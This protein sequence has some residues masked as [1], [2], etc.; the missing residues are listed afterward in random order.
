MKLFPRLALVVILFSAAS[1]LADAAD[2]PDLILD[3]DGRYLW[4]AADQALDEKGFLSEQYLGRY[5]HSLRED[6]Q[7][8]GTECKVFRGSVPMQFEPN[9]SLDELV[10]GAPSIVSGRVVAL[11]EGFYG[12]IPGT[13]LLLAAER[14][15]G[16]LSGETLLF[17]PFAQIKT[18]EGL[19]CAKASADA[20][21][22]K[23]GDRVLVFAMRGS[24][25]VRGATILNVNVGRELV[26]MPAAGGIRA[27]EALLSFC[28]TTD[29]LESL[30]L[31]IRRRLRLSHPA[32]TVAGVPPRH[33]VLHDFDPA[34]RVPPRDTDEE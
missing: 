8:N 5:T 26:H 11:R 18:A 32:P 14:L 3:E 33:E 19:V 10:R 23:L 16:E 4:V 12:G 28:G 13:L 7:L 17:Y 20:V 6:A 2:V 24:R 9:S 30:R 34:S 1:V 21:P 31:E 29:C 25:H 27:P 15:K 22:P